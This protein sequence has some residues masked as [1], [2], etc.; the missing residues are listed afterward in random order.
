MK[1]ADGTV[2]W[3]TDLSVDQSTAFQDH[4]M[5]DADTFYFPTGRT[6]PVAVNK[7]D[8]SLVRQVNFDYRRSG[9]GVDVTFLAKDVM[10]YGPNQ[11]G[12]LNTAWLAHAL[13]ILFRADFF[14]GNS[15]PF[16]TIAHGTENQ[17]VAGARVGG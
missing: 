7:T 2:V 13:S 10:S 8:G 12:V 11:S 5:I 4:I 14:Q 3:K 17:A 6:S 9:G 16:E 15:T 1:V